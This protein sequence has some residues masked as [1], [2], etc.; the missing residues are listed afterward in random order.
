MEQELKML[1]SIEEKFPKKTIAIFEAVLKLRD[2]GWDLNNL[3]VSEIAKKA[4]IGKGTIYDYLNSKEE[5]II[6]ALAY[7]YCLQVCEFDI[8][9]RQ[10]TTFEA[11]INA[12]CDWV[13]KN[14][15]RSFFLMR[16][17]K[18]DSNLMKIGKDFCEE[19]FPN[20]SSQDVF[21]KT[22]D[23]VLET[24]VKE[25]LIDY[26]KDN[27]EKEMV[28]NAVGG[29]LFTYL[30]CPEKYKEIKFT[31]VKQYAHEFVLRL[32]SKA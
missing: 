10:E 14:M 27:L 8:K 16:F 30:V 11:Q 22:V 32:L 6:K 24:G 12:V 2:E 20:G 26:P 19:L 23:Y 21:N 13:Q 15:Q 28:M 4:G 17:V 5:I 31:Q 3:T 1:K 9:I 7:E 25:D 18:A 29:A